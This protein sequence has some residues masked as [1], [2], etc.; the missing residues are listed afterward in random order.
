[1]GYEDLRIRLHFD[2]LDAQGRRCS[3]LVCAVCGAKSF[4]EAV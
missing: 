1:M 2:Q 3:R 4:S